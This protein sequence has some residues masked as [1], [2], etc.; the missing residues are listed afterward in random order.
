MAHWTATLDANWWTRRTNADGDTNYVQWEPPQGSRPRITGGILADP[1]N[2]ERFLSR[3]VLDASSAFR[4]VIH[5]TA[6]QTGGIIGGTQDLSDAWKTNHRVKVTVGDASWELPATLADDL[7]EHYIYTMSVSDQVTAFTDFIEAMTSQSEAELILWDGQ[8]A[9]PFAPASRAGYAEIS[10][11]GSSDYAR[12]QPTL[13]SRVAR[14]RWEWDSGYP[15]IPASLADGN[16]ATGIEHIEV[17]LSGSSAYFELDTSGA[18]LSGAMETGGEVRLEFAG[19]TI[20]IDNLVGFGTGGPDTSDPY[21]W[22]GGPHQNIRDMVAAAP[23]A[24]DGS[25]VL[26]LWDG[27]G[28]NP[29]VHHDSHVFIGGQAEERRYIGDR[30]VL[31]VYQGETRL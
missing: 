11:A 17:N 10:L 3:F 22:D 30:R 13:T 1:D 20:H 5:V 14:L 6:L 28:A 23:A 15:Q 7:S 26:K 29:F 27:T 21:R 9:N 2:D 18:D 31:A 8:G 12:A 25:A 24:D 4:C 19:H 16:A